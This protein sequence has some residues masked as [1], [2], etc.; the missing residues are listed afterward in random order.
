MP[1]PGV[2]LADAGLL[3]IAPLVVKIAKMR[4]LLSILLLLTL[5]ASVH[6]YNALGHRVINSAVTAP[7][8]ARAVTASS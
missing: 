6:A 8:A 2:V 1:A 7:I 3:R 4:S 5:S